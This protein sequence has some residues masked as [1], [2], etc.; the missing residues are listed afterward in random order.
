MK[1]D[2]SSPLT[3]DTVKNKQTNKEMYNFPGRSI[4]NNPQPESVFFAND[5]LSV[6][7]KHL[8]GV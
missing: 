4:G 5:I 7:H 8:V 6:L 3:S 1:R 2:E